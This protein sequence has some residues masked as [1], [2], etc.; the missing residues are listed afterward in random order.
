MIEKL[1]KRNLEIM[2]QIPIEDAL[3]YEKHL[4]IDKILSDDKCFSK[5]SFEDS[6]NI[7]MDLGYSKEDA[8][9]TYF[10]RVA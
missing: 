8:I 6:I 4:L 1:R 2:D 9:N 10:T 3:Q 5:M 7:L